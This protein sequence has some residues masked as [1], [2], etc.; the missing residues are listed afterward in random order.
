[1]D[2][3][4]NSVHWWDDFDDG[5]CHEWVTTRSFSQML[6]KSEQPVVWDIGS[7]FGYFMMV[8]SNYTLPENIHV[9]EADSAHA[10]VISLNNRIYIENNAKVNNNRVTD[11]PNDGEISGDQYLRH[12]DCPDLIKIDVDSPEADVVAGMSETIIRCSPDLLIEIHSGD[13]IVGKS[14]RIDNVLSNNSYEY[15]ICTNHRS[16]NGEWDSISDIKQTREVEDDL[17]LRCFSS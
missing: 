13:D 16:T 1:M 14:S 2:I 11:S 4:S 12:H 3:P 7:K 17:P 8:S 15:S 9:F 10:R 6:K 5:G